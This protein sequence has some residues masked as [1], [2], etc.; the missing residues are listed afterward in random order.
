MALNG[1]SSDLQAAPH[2][3]FTTSINSKEETKKKVQANERSLELTN[4]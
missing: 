2:H 3:S 4:M 1:T